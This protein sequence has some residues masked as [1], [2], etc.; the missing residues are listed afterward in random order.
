[1]NIAILETEVGVLDRALADLS[2]AG[3]FCLGVSDDHGLKFLLDDVSIDVVILNWEAPD[4]VRYDTLRWL[5]RAYPAIRVV[6]CVTQQTAECDIVRGLDSGADVYIEKPPGNAESLARITALGRHIKPYPDG[7]TEQVVFGEYR[8]DKHNRSVQV[9]GR[10]VTLTPKEFD[11]ALLLF[12][13]LSETISRHRIATA[14]WHNDAMTKS[15]SVGTHVCALRKKLGLHPE[16]GY[17]VTS[18]PRWGYRLDPV[19]RKQGRQACWSLE[20]MT[21]TTVDIADSR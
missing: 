21:R 11:L 6:L 12:R 18:L 2:F 8:F 19:D 3:H 15:R 5:S 17:R 10:P 9:R 16:N 14:V 13:N 4:I 1:M 20:A 7:D